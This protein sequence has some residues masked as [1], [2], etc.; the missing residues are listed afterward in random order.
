MKN[1]LIAFVVFLVWSFFGLWLYSWLQPVD[2]SSRVQDTIATIENSELP[3]NLDDPLKIDDTLQLSVNSS[4]TT[5]LTENEDDP[6]VLAVPS[7]GLKASALDGD[8]I[9]AYEEGIKI[10]KN[11]NQLEYATELTEFK[12]KLGTYLQEHPEEELHI[13][14]L[15]SATENIGSPNFGYQRGE[16]MKRILTT[17]GLDSKRIIVKSVIREIDFDENGLFQNGISFSFHP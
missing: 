3:L 16:K 13:A 6:P 9:F 14:S 5:N 17:A 4:D 10:W 15:Y 8:L 2:N 11:T 7:T 12:N 1:F